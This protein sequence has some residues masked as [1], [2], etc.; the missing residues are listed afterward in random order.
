MGYVYFPFGKLSDQGYTSLP[1]PD[2]SESGHLH[3]NYLL[4]SL[5]NT[6]QSDE[7]SNVSIVS[8]SGLTILESESITFREL[9]IA[10]CAP[11]LDIL[12]LFFFSF[13]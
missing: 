2:E 8:N 1:N 3:Y 9:D 11:S 13:I 12:G 10:L 5:V 7:Y 4:T 6:K